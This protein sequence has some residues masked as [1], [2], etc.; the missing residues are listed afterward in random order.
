M[1]WKTTPALSLLRTYG[2]KSVIVRHFAVSLAILFVPLVVSSVVVFSS[3]RGSLQE[4]AKSRTLNELERIRDV[5]DGLL[6]EVVYQTASISLLSETQRYVVSKP[7]ET[8]LARVPPEIVRKVTRMYTLSNQ[9]VHSIYVFSDPKNQVVTP[10]GVHALSTFGDQGWYELYRDA[11]P[12][13]IAKS[14]R[15]IRDSWPPVITIMRIISPSGST[16]RFGAVVANIDMFQ[17]Q[18]LLRS[19]RAIDRVYILDDANTVV[20]SPRYDEIGLAAESI[21]AGLVS[22][23]DEEGVGGT[24]DEQLGAFV[25]STPSFSGPWTYV[26]LHSDESY[27]RALVQ[28]TRVFI[29][30]VSASFVLLS[31]V[32]SLIAIHASVPVQRM[33]DLF[34][35]PSSEIAEPNA[36]GDEIRLI[37]SNVSRLIASNRELEAEVSS[38]LNTL[39]KMRYITLQSQINPHFLYNTLE[40]INWEAM[41]LANGENHVSAMISALSKCIRMGMSS[42]EDTVPLRQEIAHGRMYLSLMSLRFPNRFTDSWNVDE[43][44]LDCRVPRVMLQPIL[45]NSVNHGLNLADGPGKIAV[46]VARRDS[47]LQI[48]VSDNGV[49]VSEDHAAALNRDMRSQYSIRRNHIGLANIAQRIRSLYGD[50]YG[51]R[52]A[53]RSDSGFDGTGVDVTIRIPLC[54]EGE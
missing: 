39:E 16:E 3:T 22:L 50:S 49:G 42:D 31:V 53:N 15:F 9:L 28:T 33:L 25:A 52:I 5:T 11:T 32:T 38:H 18:R 36:T 27:R 6:T 51:C 45:E 34:Q 26:L 48:T 1:S 40:A 14:F 35:N 41:R 7:S 37:A 17:L 47:G 24:Y 30:V 12:D 4:D 46:T 20:L 29:L 54:V 19:A 2:T 8:I 23:G 43:D 21:D 10:S 44:L 13:A